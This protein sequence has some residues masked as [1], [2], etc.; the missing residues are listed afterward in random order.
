LRLQLDPRAPLQRGYVL[1]TTPEGQVVK[2]RANAAGKPVLRLEFADGTLDVAPAA[3]PRSPTRK[4]PPVG[5]QE[6]F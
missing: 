3:T 1:V 4:A 6:L 2:D 5:Q